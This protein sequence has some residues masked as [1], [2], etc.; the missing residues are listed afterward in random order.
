MNLPPTY[1]FSNFEGT[2]LQKR[3]PYSCPVQ[4]NAQDSSSWNAQQAQYSKNSGG[5]S[6]SYSYGGYQNAP[7][8]SRTSLSTP[9]HFDGSME[10]EDAFEVG[11]F[12]SKEPGGGDSSVVSGANL[13]AGVLPVRIPALLVG[14]QFCFE[15]VLVHDK[16]DLVMR[17]QYVSK[18]WQE[19]TFVGF[20]SKLGRVELFCI[21]LAV[22]VLVSVSIFWRVHK[23]HTKTK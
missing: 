18:E 20:V 8:P 17:M 16:A 14:D 21:I 10:Q 5:G 15:G 2:D 1:T 7:M 11:T 19:K 22:C 12:A 6:S 23:Q 9:Q 3:D 13:D 4:P